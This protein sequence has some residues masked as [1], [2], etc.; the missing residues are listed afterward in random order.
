MS[1]FFEKDKQPRIR[2]LVGDVG[3]LFSKWKINLYCDRFNLK[4]RISLNQYVVGN[5]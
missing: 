2:V 3:K 5:G 1:V 4:D